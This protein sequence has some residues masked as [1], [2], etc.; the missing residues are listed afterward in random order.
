[1][2]KSEWILRFIRWLEKA[3]IV[4]SVQL[5][6]IRWA[7]PFT[8]LVSIFFPITIIV[9]LHFSNPHMTRSALIEIIAGNVV[10][11]SVQ[12]FLTT[13]PQMIANMRETRAIDFF[14]T[15]PVS[16]SSFMLGLVG[17]FLVQS[18]V[19]VVIVYAVSGLF[20]DQ[21]LFPGV[22][23]FLAYTLL[24]LSLI[25]LGAVI[26]IFSRNSLMAGSIGGLAG[27]LCTFLMPVYYPIRVLPL[28]L[29]WLAR[30]TPVYYARNLL[31]GGLTNSYHGNLFLDLF[32]LG[33]YAVLS[34]LLFGRVFQ[35]RSAKSL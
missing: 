32:V 7:G 18:F 5:L 10:A 2:F 26:A 28:I 14:A 27:M 9:L 25:S 11:S 22:M 15:L 31:M 13:T 29:Q 19:D 17:S 1:M 3:G 6:N 4:A 30:I 23:S 33:S 34:T 20:L 21:F 12:L 24:T 8:F 35:W 16:K